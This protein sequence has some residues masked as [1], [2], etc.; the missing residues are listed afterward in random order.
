MQDFHQEYDFL[1]TKKQ[2]KD[3]LVRWAFRKRLNKE[4][5]ARICHLY[6]QG[7]QQ[8]RDRTVYFNREPKTLEDIRAYIR[9][10]PL[11]ATEEDLLQ[12]L[13]VDN[14]SPYITWLDTD[15][16]PATS[17]G[18]LLSVPA[19]DQ[20]SEIAA[21][22]EQFRVDWTAR[23]HSP[24]D[25]QLAREVHLEAIPQAPAVTSARRPESGI[26]NIMSQSL[27]VANKLSDARRNRK[28]T[29][30]LSTPLAVS[31]RPYPDLLW[32]AMDMMAWLQ[33]SFNVVLLALDY[34]DQISLSERIAS[35][36]VFWA[37]V[38]ISLKLA[39]TLLEDHPFT[40]HFWSRVLDKHGISSSTGFRLE[41]EILANPDFHPLPAQADWELMSYEARGAT[42]AYLHTI[43]SALQ[44]DN[45]AGVAGGD[46]VVQPN[47]PDTKQKPE[48]AT[49]WDAHKDVIRSLYLDQNCTLRQ[50]MDTMQK[51]RGFTASERAYRQKLHEWG[52]RKNGPSFP[53]T[54]IL[55]QNGGS[56]LP[57]P[58]PPPPPPSWPFSSTP[59][60]DLLALTTGQSD[61][62][63]GAGAG[64]GAPRT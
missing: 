29:P 43:S 37:R 22:H 39:H 4:D 45:P 10:S 46:A 57:P 42:R 26:E 9:K 11:V 18:H 23:D 28:F 16:D 32:Q 56:R 41:R 59:Q 33:V 8:G 38:I 40:S 62:G 52:I 7:A 36:Y 55:Q 30:S 64:A 12:Y 13:D 6:R 34:F 44:T 58:P 3:Q 50:I 14:R 35:G 27:L 25:D 1:A 47:P 21:S 51:Q 53:G 31:A 49:V 20:P 60:R 24:F 61:D 48:S 5:S 2:W 19:A 54:G 15:P 17:P 63:A